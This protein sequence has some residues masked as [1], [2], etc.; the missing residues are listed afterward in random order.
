MALFGKLVEGFKKITDEYLGTSNEGSAESSAAA[1]VDPLHNAALDRAFSKYIDHFVAYKEECIREYRYSHFIDRAFDEYFNSTVGS[2]SYD[3]I[4]S[5]PEDLK[6]TQHYRN[7][8]IDVMDITFSQCAKKLKEGTINVA[9]VY[10][11]VGDLQLFEEFKDLDLENALAHKDYFASELKAARSVLDPN[12]PVREQLDQILKDGAPDSLGAFVEIQSQ[13]EHA[14]TDKII[15][16]KQLSDEQ[17]DNFLVMHHLFTA[18]KTEHLDELKRAFL[19]L[20]LED[21]RGIL[22]WGSNMMTAK[23]IRAI[24][25]IT[26]QDEEGAVQLYPCVDAILADAIRKTKSGNLDEFNPV[27]KDW[28][29]TAIGYIDDDQI[30]LVQAAL[31][32]IG[33][34]S[35]EQILLQCIMDVGMPH[36]VEQ[37]K[38]LAFLRENQNI[39]NQD[40]GKYTPVAEMQPE[41]SSDG[42]QENQVLIYD[43]RFHSWNTN[44]VE[45]YFKGLTLAAKQ[46]KVAAVVDKWAKTVTLQGMKWDNAVVTE[47]V[48]ETVAS[49]FGDGY[50][51]SAVNA[52]VVIDDEV[53][54]TPAVFIQASKDNRYPDIS[55]LVVGEP[56]TRTQI[57]LSILILAIPDLTDDSNAKLLKRIVAVKEKHNPR[58]DTYIETFKS[59]ITD[60]LNRWIVDMNADQGIY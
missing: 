47:I 1:Y 57:H 42:S 43:H 58:L 53:D 39:L 36:T 59:I 11:A 33:A 20:A 32:A 55:L 2:R 17:A 22:N 3:L 52:G 26:C 21:D 50:S 46:H 12:A 54:T 9:N 48:R 14:M 10:R 38:R 56:M 16:G 34:Y 41:V 7:K 25:G 27:F 37:E 6:Q 45:K 15:L 19:Y 8:L 44:D 29:Y 13:I 24:F 28:I 5:I 30:H 40:F 51:V 31:N 49:E 23:L 35:T 4:S 18:L 60:R